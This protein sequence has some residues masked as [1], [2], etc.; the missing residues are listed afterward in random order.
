MI[1]IVTEM[2]AAPSA[3]ISALL[4]GGDKVAPFVMGKVNSLSAKE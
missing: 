1:N 4:T 2:L 3:S